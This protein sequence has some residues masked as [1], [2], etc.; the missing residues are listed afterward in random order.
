MFPLA[1]VTGSSIAVTYATIELFLLPLRASREFGLDRVAV[2]RLLMIA[3]VSDIVALLPVGLVADRA[4]ASRVLAVILCS[5]ASAAAL[6]T[7]GGVGAM[8]AGAALF[9]L[10]MAGWMLPLSLLRRETP[11][12]DI[13]WRTALYRVGVDG[14]LFLG[15]FLCGLLGDAAWVLAATFAAVLIALAFVL[16]TRSAGSR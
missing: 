6:V 15:P 7:F 9:G 3:Q 8:A 2:A 10:G 16:F 4:G 5:L 12:P 11:A 1:F 14:G 13:A